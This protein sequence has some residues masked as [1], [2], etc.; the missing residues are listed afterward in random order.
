MAKFIELTGQQ[1]GRLNVLYATKERERHSRD[2]IWQCVCDCGNS[3]RVRTSS[4]KLGITKSCGCLRRENAA[5]VSPLGVESRRRKR[6]TA[7]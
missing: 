5:R 7:A 6:E 4:L 1:F 2:V 3:C